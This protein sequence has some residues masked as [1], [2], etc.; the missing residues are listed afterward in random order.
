MDY[1][2]PVSMIPPAVT[3]KSPISWTVGPLR[4]APQAK[5]ET[6][7]SAV[8]RAPSIRFGFALPMLENAPHKLLEDLIQETFNDEDRCCFIRAA[9]TTPQQ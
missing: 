5:N 1:L 8:F 2:I 3:N 6:P 9:E 7:K 4:R